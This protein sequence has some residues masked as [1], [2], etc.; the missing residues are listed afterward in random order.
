M[1]QSKNSSINVEDLHVENQKLRKEMAQVKS[2]MAQMAQHLSAQGLLTPEPVRDEVPLEEKPWYVKQGSE[3]HAHLLDL[4]RDD[5]SDKGW[6]LS[7]PTVW[8][9]MANSEF[10]TLILDQK[11]N[12]LTS[13]APQM[14]SVSPLSP[15]FAIPLWVPID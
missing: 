10:L 2:L 15:N 3:R 7:D 1:A 4:V 11:I 6:K 5:S 9:P 12:E 13:S 8:G 14:Q